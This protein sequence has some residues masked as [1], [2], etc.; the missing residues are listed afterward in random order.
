MVTDFKPVFSSSWKFTMC[1]LSLEE[2]SAEVCSLSA[3][4]QSSQKKSVLEC[5]KSCEKYTSDPTLITD[6]ANFPMSQEE[7]KSK[8]YLPSESDGF[9]IYSS[10]IRIGMFTYRIKPD[11]TF[12]IPPYDYTSTIGTTVNY[13]S[14]H[15]SF[16][17]LNLPCVSFN[18]DDVTKVR[19]V[20]C[21]FFNFYNNK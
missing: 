2:N 11:N 10:L 8:F 16:N 20:W 21:S 7:L 3:P 4:I 6:P 5:A 12:E 14:L 1:R 18:Y 9:K 19:V 17:L 15:V 13:N